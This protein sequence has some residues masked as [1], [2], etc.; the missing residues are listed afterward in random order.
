MAMAALIVL[1]QCPDPA[2]ADT[3]A[4]ALVDARL[5]ACVTRLAPARSVYHWQGT[6]E[7]AEEIPLL[8]KTTTDRYPALETRLRELHPYAVPEIVALPVTRGL[9]AYLG[10]L[11]G[12]VAP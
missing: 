5:A 3:I 8:I 2:V 10:W 1:T 9:P 7:T 6:V 12:E 11:A 4:R